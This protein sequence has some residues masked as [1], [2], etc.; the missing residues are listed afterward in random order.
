MSL[1]VWLPGFHTQDSMLVLPLG[2]VNGKLRL[3]VPPICPIRHWG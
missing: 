2:E 1:Y 3:Y